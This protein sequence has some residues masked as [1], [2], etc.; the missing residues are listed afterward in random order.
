MDRT[1]VFTRINRLVYLLLIQKNSTIHNSSQDLIRNI[2][3]TFLPLFDFYHLI[4]F[5]STK[6]IVIKIRL[7]RGLKLPGSTL[8]FFMKPFIRVSLHLSCY[9][10]KYSQ[11]RRQ[12]KKSLYI[13]TYARNFPVAYWASTPSTK[14]E[15]KPLGVGI[16]KSSHRLSKTIGLR[17]YFVGPHRMLVSCSD[18]ESFFESCPELSHPG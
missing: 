1:E 6:R 16:L 18:I 14:R 8:S 10:I 15:S 3:S 2:K 5:T 7:W 12:K 11:S 13:G 17:T 9:R 4:L